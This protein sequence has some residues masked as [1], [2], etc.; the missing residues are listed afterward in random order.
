MTSGNP[1]YFGKCLV[2]KAVSNSDRSIA[3]LGERTTGPR[4]PPRDLR[5]REG[6]VV[7]GGVVIEN[8]CWGHEP[9]VKMDARRWRYGAILKK[10]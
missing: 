2:C 1:Q 10:E 4:W 5:M 9:R 7:R 6:H 8:C 3:G